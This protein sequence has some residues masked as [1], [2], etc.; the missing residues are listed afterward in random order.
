MQIRADF[1]RFQH[2]IG[3]AIQSPN[4][5]GAITLLKPDR[6]SFSNKT[7]VLFIES[8]MNERMYDVHTYIIRT[9]WLESPAD[10]QSI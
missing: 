4:Y 10:G 3:K 1:I 9:N 7:C 2:L 8:Q 6:M 5:V